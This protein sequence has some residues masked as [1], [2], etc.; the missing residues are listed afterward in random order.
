LAEH[1]DYAD[2]KVD[3][4]PVDSGNPVRI[5]LSPGGSIEGRTLTESDRKPVT[6]ARVLA[7]FEGKIK[8][9]VVSAT[10]G[11][12]LIKG[13]NPGSYDL[14]ATCG[15]LRSEPL[16]DISVGL[17]GTVSGIEILLKPG[18]VIRGEVRSVDT[19]E[20]VPGATVQTSDKKFTAQSNASGFYRLEGLPAEKFTLT[21]TAEGF[22]KS[23]TAVRTVEG[24]E[25][26]CDF[27][28]EP[29]GDVIVRVRDEKDAPIEEAQVLLIEGMTP[30]TDM[31]QTTDSEGVANI[32]GVSLR[33]PPMVMAV[34]KGYGIAMPTKPEF[35]P[36]S[37]VAEVKIVLKSTGPGG[38][39][40][41]RV[42]DASD[43]PLPDAKVR[44][45]SP[46]DQE[47]AEVNTDAEGN[48]LIEVK[49]QGMMSQ[50]QAS[51]EGYAPKTKM[52]LT[53]GTEEEP[54]RADFQLDPAH[55]LDVLAVDPDG[56]P[57]PNLV[58]MVL[59]SGFPPMPVAGHDQPNHTGEDGR[60]H[61]EG[62][63]GPSVSLMVMGEGWSP[64]QNRTVDVDREVR[65]TL[66]PKGVLR[67]RV[68][69]K[70]TE[71]PIKEFTVSMAANDMFSFIQGPL[72]ETFSTSD[73]R[74]VMSGLDLG[75]EYQVTVDAG[76][77]GSTVKKGVSGHSEDDETEEVFYLSGEGQLE[78]IVYD[79]K[80]GK[81][82][83][84]IRVVHALYGEF[85]IFDWDNLTDSNP[86]LQAVQSAV[87]GADGRFSFQESEEQ[88]TIL[89]NAKGYEKVL[90]RPGERTL[91]ADLGCLKS[92]FRKGL[93]SKASITT[94]GCRFLPLACF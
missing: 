73:G 10:E 60:C 35:P 68:L 86:A 26:V 2:G 64:I 87:T 7:L 76:K 58:V 15:N 5:V 21:C 18:M 75:K 49:G 92:R 93:R 89:I 3:N 40:A 56:K 90:M 17:S 80:G 42:T 61:F 94:G 8:K 70:K 91:N 78:G 48:Y 27:S 37:K 79:S 39:F 29:G 14:L 20:A 81:P 54:A 66:Y 74:F 53:P 36:E 34:K 71:E 11:R 44:W 12:F 51:A 22:A 16:K 82:L 67:G 62:L 32:K 1:P 6:E 23:E 69:N 13:L 83:S 50:L 24:Q 57:V 19:G 25:Q 31:M 28:L 30:R 88:G 63:P 85:P 38:F 59:S 55:W 46:M 33:N 9:Q 65:L 43:S 72:K 52:N 84:G 47:T 45:L 4:A 41:G 77:A